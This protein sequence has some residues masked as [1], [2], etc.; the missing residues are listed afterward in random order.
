MTY[1]S[2]ILDEIEKLSLR[3]YEADMKSAMKELPTEALPPEPLEKVELTITSEPVGAEIEINGE[4]I[5]NTPTTIKTDP[6]L[7]QFK[8]TLSDYKVWER[9]L[10][11]NPGD[12]RTIHIGLI[13]ENP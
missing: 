3:A 9:S 13:N 6:G 1:E 2:K 11:T 12:K 7:T 4:W 10:Q 5:G 8:I